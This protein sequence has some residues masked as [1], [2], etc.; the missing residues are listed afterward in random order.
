[1]F[2]LHSTTLLYD[3]L[4]KMMKANSKTRQLVFVCF[5]ILFTSS[6]KAD[7]QQEVVSN[8]YHVQS[9]NADSSGKSLKAILQLI[10][11]NNSSVYGP[12]IPLLSL[13]AR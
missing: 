1:M 5:L 2:S 3:P 13:T 10:D 7:D 12:Q 11:G 9:V 6:I 8:G 4:L